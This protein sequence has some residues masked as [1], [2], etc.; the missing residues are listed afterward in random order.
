MATR[1]GPLLAPA[2]QISARRFKP[3]SLTSIPS[4]FPKET[5]MQYKTIVLELLSQHPQIQQQLVSRRT[6][7]PVLERYARELKSKH[8]HW[9]AR[10]GQALPG[11]NHYQIASE[12]LEIALREMEHCLRADFPPGDREPLTLEGAMAFLRGR[13]STA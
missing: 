11:S 7:L 6:L 10:L 13:G 8:E 4:H 1:N 12:A 5:K 2:L 9:K 3:A